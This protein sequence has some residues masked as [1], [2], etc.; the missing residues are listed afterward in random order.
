MSEALHEGCSL[1]KAAVRGP[2]CLIWYSNQECLEIELALQSIPF[3]Q[4]QQLT[5]TYKQKPL[6]QIY[7][8]DLICYEQIILEIKAVSQLCDAFRAQ[9]HNYLKATGYGLGLL[10]NFGHY[11][12]IEWERIVR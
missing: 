12:K 5:L 9:V 10:V 2:K 3:R 7:I 8:P 1:R 6:K 11:P 4:H